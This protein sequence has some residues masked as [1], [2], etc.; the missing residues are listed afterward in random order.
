VVVEEPKKL[1]EVLTPK[2]PKTPFPTGKVIA[3]VLA[4]L[5]GASA[6]LPPPWNFVAAGVFK[7]LQAA[8]GG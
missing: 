2:P 1:P 7:L 6:F 5:V 4:I 3:T 8:V